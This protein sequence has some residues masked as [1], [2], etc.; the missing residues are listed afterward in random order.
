MSVAIV[1]FH[2]Y[3]HPPLYAGSSF[4]VLQIRRVALR[5]KYITVENCIGIASELLGIARKIH[6]VF[7]PNRVMFAE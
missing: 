5:L 1:L 4:A 2:P 7:E 6:Q 3:T